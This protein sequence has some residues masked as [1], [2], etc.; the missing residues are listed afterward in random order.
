VTDEVDIAEADFE[1]G[2]SYAL[3]YAFPWIAEGAIKHQTQF[4]VRLGHKTLE[5]DGRKTSNL[6]GRSDILLVHNGQPLAVLEL[7]RPGLS[8]HDDDRL[9]GLSYARLME[10]WP[11]LVIVTNGQTIKLFSVFTGAPWTPSNVS[12]ETFNELITS[13]GKLAADSMRNAVETLIGPT[14][15]TW[16]SIVRSI[17][18]HT[19][20]SLTGPWEDLRAPFPDRLIFPRKATA[21]VTHLLEKR[22]RGVILTGAPLSGKSNVL[23]HLVIAAGDDEKRAVLLLDGNSSQQGILQTLANGMTSAFGW[24]MT[25]DDVRSWLM[26]LSRTDRGPML[27]LAIDGGDPSL[28]RP[29]LDEFT[30][31]SYGDRLQIVIAVDDGAAEMLTTAS[32]G[33]QETQFGRLAEIAPIGP[34]DDDEFEQAGRVLHHYRIGFMHGAQRESAYRL[35]WML[36]TIAGEIMSDDQYKD[37]GTQATIPS[38]ASFEIFDFASRRCG[39]S[40]ALMGR[41]VKLAEAIIADC[42]A[43]NRP[44]AFSVAS[45]L[46]VIC[47]H[48]TARSAVGETELQRLFDDGYLRHGLLR[49]G[50]RIV[51]PQLPELLLPA[52]SIV[53]A[54]EFRSALSTDAV[55]ATHRLI[56][57]C[58]LLPTGDLIGAYALIEVAK[59]NALPIDVFNALLADEPREE[60]AKAGSRALMPLSDGQALDIEF[61]TDGGALVTAPDGS[62]HRM[63][64]DP[65]EPESPLLAN[66]TSW[67]ILSHLAAV[68]FAAVRQGETEILG[69]LDPAILM[70]VGSCRLPLMRPARGVIDGV[71]EHNLGGDGRMVCH[72]EGI[73]EPITL[74]L[75]RT[76]R[77]DR[78]NG[79]H[80]VDQAV[81]TQ[82]LP[83][84]TRLFTAL[85]ELSRSR[86]GEVKA[87]ATDTLKNSIRPAIGDANLVH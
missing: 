24:S 56:S 19:L 33:R 35:P 47:R 64:P 78:E 6:R 13:S 53:L 3:K 79:Q 86:D 81:Q 49:D 65:D 36:R 16:T 18:E 41:F 77:G 11:P 55:K 12:E 44:R 9:Q 85:T 37:E 43:A 15:A 71:H 52:L 54:N 31:A 69:R 39:R 80:I 83:L 57:R 45:F 34:L 5:I 17:T 7:K 75:L 1:A 50:T 62:R 29:E 14:S 20:K 22:T 87:W 72:Q 30:S 25:R 2:L 76:L 82:G 23:R 70:H 84:L 21:Y 67:L 61:L 4:S 59:Q 42:D 68:P 48:D 63:E 51:V 26:K 73:I 46:T 74:A 66:Q 60:A 32:S 8:L 40:P 28:L 58:A 27:T 38:L 10:P